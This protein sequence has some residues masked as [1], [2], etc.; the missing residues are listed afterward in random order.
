MERVWKLVFNKN[1][2]GRP[3]IVIVEKCSTILGKD[4]AKI[5]SP[6]A[7]EAEDYAEQLAVERGWDLVAV[8]EI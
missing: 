8:E 4:G 3:P 2:V 7:L 1:V 5:A 6:N